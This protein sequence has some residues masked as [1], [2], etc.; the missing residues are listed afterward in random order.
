MANYNFFS[1]DSEEAQ[2][3]SDLTNMRKLKRGEY[4]DVLLTFGI[5]HFHIT[6]YLAFIVWFH[7]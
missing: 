4:Q 6:I 2:I 3:T 1:Y 5:E 7:V